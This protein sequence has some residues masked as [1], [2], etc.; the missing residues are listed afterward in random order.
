MAEW[1]GIDGVNN[2]SLIQAGIWESPIVGTNSFCITPWWEILPATA[3]SFSNDCTIMN[4]GDS[5]TVHIYETTT[6]NLW[7][8]SVV[9]NTNGQSFSTQQYYYGPGDSAEWIVEAPTL[10]QGQATL[11]P[12]SPVTFTNPKYSLAPSG[13]VDQQTKDVMIQNGSTVSVPSNMK[14]NGSFTVNY[15]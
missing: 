4:V 13:G 5:I 12:Y 10:S 14:S 1:V 6:P 7:E 3:T 11:S 2:S 9:D 8:I 15:Q